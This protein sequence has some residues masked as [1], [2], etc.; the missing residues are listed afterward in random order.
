MG[1]DSFLEDKMARV[2]AIL[3]Q[4]QGKKGTLHAENITDS[5]KNITFEEYVEPVTAENWTGGYEEDGEYT[6][7]GEYDEEGNHVGPKPEDPQGEEAKNKNSGDGYSD[8]YDYG[9]GNDNYGYDNYGYGY[10]SYG[11]T[12][13]DYGYGYGYDNYGYDYSYGYD[14]YAY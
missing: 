8:G 1:K 13:N 5:M 9:Y 3:P 2:I 14:S 10:D 12:Y 11:N 7:T 6:G 4:I